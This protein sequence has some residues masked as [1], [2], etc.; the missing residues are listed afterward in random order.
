MVTL[1]IKKVCVQC[2]EET[3][4]VQNKRTLEPAMPVHP[5]SHIELYLGGTFLECEACGSTTHMLH[6]DVGSQEN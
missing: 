6:I 5:G 3:H 1:T 4:C 2:G